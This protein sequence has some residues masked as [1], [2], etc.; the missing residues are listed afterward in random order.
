M[1]PGYSGVSRP[2]RALFLVAVR[3][4]VVSSPY[5][6]A[7]VSSAPGLAK[8]VGGCNPRPGGSVLGSTPGGTLSL[9]LEGPTK[10]TM[11]FH[12]LHSAAGALC[13]WKL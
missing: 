6:T 4:T 13:Y 1:A 8:L 11:G 12:Q 2:R 7:G 3:Y 9:S 5:F 10:L